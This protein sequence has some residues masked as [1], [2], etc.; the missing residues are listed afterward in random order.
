M[1][2]ISFENSTIN[3][4]MG[5]IMTKPDSFPPQKLSPS[6]TNLSLTYPP[7]STL[8]LKHPIPRQRIASVLANQ[9]TPGGQN[10]ILSSNP[11]SDQIYSSKKHTPHTLQT[12]KIR[13]PILHIL[14]PNSLSLSFLDFHHHFLSF[15]NSV[16]QIA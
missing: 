12:T 5:Y 1:Q 16:L 2:C 11:L 15:G 13:A 10:P 6:T 7:I 3:F 9:I 4:H 8:H 14:N